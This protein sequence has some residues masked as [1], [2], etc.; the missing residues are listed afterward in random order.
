M[1][2]NPRADKPTLETA[3]RF[4]RQ[5]DQATAH[6]MIANLVQDDPENVQAWSWLA[7]VAESVEQKRAA[8]RKALKLSPVDTRIHDALE[9]LSSPQLIEQA[10]HEGVFISYTRADELFAFDLAHSLRSSGVNV[11]IDMTDIPEDEDWYAAVQNALD[12]TGLMLVVLTPSALVDDDLHGEWQYFVERGKLV[13]PLLREKCDYQ[14]QD[15][16]MPPVDFR[17]DYTLGF[18]NLLKLLAVDA[19]WHS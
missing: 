8:L 13:L 12:Y 10:V 19:A 5:G 11:W 18:Q 2:S 9:R 17:Y 7:Y 14:N 15:F 16:W 1:S 3:I 6:K 4:L